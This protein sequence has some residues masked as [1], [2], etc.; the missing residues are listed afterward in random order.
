MEKRVNTIVVE[1]DMEIKVISY[2]DLIVDRLNA[3]KWWKD[4]NSFIWAKVLYK[5]KEE[6]GEE[7]DINYLKKE[8]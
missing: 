2:E 8:Q 4:S 5:A 7:I 1:K 3:F 6:I